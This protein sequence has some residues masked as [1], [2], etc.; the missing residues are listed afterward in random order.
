MTTLGNRPDE[1]ATLARNIDAARLRA[2]GISYRAIADRL[3]Y[4]SASGAHYAVMAL[5][6]ES[7]AETAEPMRDLV[8][9]RLLL[10]TSRTG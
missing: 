7:A 2:S 6:R 8:Y 9:A 4:A 5:L 10:S 1:A 3:G